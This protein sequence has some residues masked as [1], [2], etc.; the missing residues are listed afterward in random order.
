MNANRL[1]PALPTPWAVFALIVGLYIW[2]YAPCGIDNND[3][4][5]I[6]GLAHQVSLGGLLYDHIVYVRPPVSPVMH[7]FVF[8]WPFY[9]AP[10]L[11]DRVFV[12]LQISLYSALSAVLAGRYF[13]WS[14]G[15]TALT[16]TLAFVF[17]AHVFPPMAWHTIDGI[18]FSVLALYCMAA[19][20][21][22]HRG[23][24]LLS[25]CSGILAAG[26]KQPFLLFPFML[27]ALV[28]ILERRWLPLA[29][30]SLS[31]LASVMLFFLL[32]NRFGSMQMFW[33]A[34]SSQTTARDLWYAGF[35]NYVRSLFHEDYR[36]GAWPLLALLPVSLLRRVSGRLAPGVLLIAA[37]VML[38]TSLARFYL[39][40]ADSYQPLELFNSIFVVTLLCSLAMLAL[41]RHES[42][43][44]VVAMHGI[45]WC[46]SISWGYLTP[47]L[48]SAPSV[49]T[50]ACALE[51]CCRRYGGFRIASF[52]L[53]PAALALFWQGHQLFYSLEGP[54]RRVDMTADMGG[55][56]PVLRGIRGTPEQFALYSELEEMIG[57]AGNG[58]Y[59]VLPDITFAH[60]LTGQPNPL[61]ID[62]VLNTEVGSYRQT[63]ARRLD[64]SVD[65]AIVY[66]KASP[67]PDLPGKFGS[68]PTMQVIRTWRLLESSDNFSLYVNPGRHGV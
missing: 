67:R 19:G 60:V 42:W 30:Y 7:S 59:V 33:G 46:A 29:I 10:I 44:W 22:G 36:Y 68:E 6:L 49:I 12:F 57:H 3:T 50:V 32:L 55:I 54:V 45:A 21:K 41:T 11:V 39:A 66:R 38:L 2:L 64:S 34:I 52:A 53:L 24:L 37:V 27:L 28:P 35:E 40:A 25:A 58:P 15:F 26:S 18:F 1:L 17:S 56:S 23:F 43:I 13:S 9:L 61:G 8:S 63:V 14:T 48:Y 65:Y 47:V 20:M 62:W 31:L 4:G 51:P 16:A 5:F